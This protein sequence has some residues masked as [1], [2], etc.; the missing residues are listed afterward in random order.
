MENKERVEIK[1]ND[2]RATKVTKISEVANTK[3]QKLSTHGQQQV[4]G[5]QVTMGDLHL[6]A[7]MDGGK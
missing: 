7:V 2:A 4:F 6:V 5:L 1:D 3:C